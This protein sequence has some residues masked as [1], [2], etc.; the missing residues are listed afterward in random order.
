[1]GLHSNY[2]CLFLSLG[3]WHCIRLHKGRM[4]NWRC[5]STISWFYYSRFASIG[6]GMMVI[7]GIYL[8]TSKLRLVWT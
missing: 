2:G 8:T 1:M 3:V 4:I 6:H 7:Q 5:S